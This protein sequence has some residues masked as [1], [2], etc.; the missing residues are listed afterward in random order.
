MFPGFP[1][2]WLP[3]QPVPVSALGF[4]SARDAERVVKELGLPLK[5]AKAE[6]VAV[7]PPPRPEVV[8]GVDDGEGDA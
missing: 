2:V 7:D 6:A 1:G 5:S 3:D 8:A 4:E